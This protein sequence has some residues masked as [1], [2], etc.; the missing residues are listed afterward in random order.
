MVINVQ[1]KVKMHPFTQTL[2][3]WYA[4][5]GR[6]LPWRTAPTP[7][8]V[9]L[10]EIILQQTQVQQGLDYYHRFL[11]AFPTVEDLAHATETEVLTL[12]A[13]LGYY[14]RAR[15]LLA[16]AQQVVQM[17]QFPRT[18]AE[19]KKLRG[20]G[21]YTAAAIASIAFGEPAAVVDGNVFRVLARYFA[22]ATPIDTS[23]GRSHFQQLAD[24]L[25]DAAHP[26]RHNQALM[27]F[28]AL[29]CVPRAPQCDVCPLA[30]SCLAH[31]QHAV[32][33][34]PVKV[35]AIKKKPRHLIYLFLSDG[36]HT[37]LRSRSG[38]DIWRGLY[39][40]LLYEPAEGEDEAAALAHLTHQLPPSATLRP[41]QL[42]VQ[43]TLTHRQLTI[44]FYAAR[45]PTGFRVDG[46]ERVALADAAC[47]PFPRPVEKIAEV[48]LEKIGRS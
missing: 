8:H 19:L 28:G 25:L 35:H 14:S 37:F 17:G 4:A 13:G 5:N 18:A 6:R 30:S 10:S 40:P 9:W 2:S 44:D 41:L 12:W 45:V 29:Q 31:A 21:P 42:G 39:E 11:R 43:H 48:W 33:S 15:N 34:F 1:N 23:A 32:A 24:Q 38:N 20:V 16:A 3:D 26:A 47:L 36:T 22:D 46:F 7:Y 27:D